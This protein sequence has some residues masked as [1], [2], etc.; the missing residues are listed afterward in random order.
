MGMTKTNTLPAAGALGDLVRSIFEPGYNYVSGKLVGVAGGTLANQAGKRVLGQPVKAS[1]ANW[2]PVLA[3]DE[4][5]ATGIIADDGIY[6]LPAAAAVSERSFTILKRGPALIG[7][8]SLPTNDLMGTAFTAATLVTALAAL[9]PPIIAQ[10][11]VTPTL[12]QS[13]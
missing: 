12:T 3:T 5:N 11:E 13:T 6:D 10:S 2:I 7:A 9:N 4:A 8:T 1:G